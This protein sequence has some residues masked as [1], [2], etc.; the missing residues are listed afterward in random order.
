MEYI[1]ANS[2]QKEDFFAES[3]TTTAP[4]TR[5]VAVSPSITYATVPKVS[6]KEPLLTAIA[7]PWEMALA[8]T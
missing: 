4:T 2:L 5:P 3:G 6:L 7:T 8:I 1:P